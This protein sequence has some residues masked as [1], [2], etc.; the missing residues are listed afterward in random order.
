MAIWH[1]APL[2]FAPAFKAIGVCEQI[3]LRYKNLDPSCFDPIQKIWYVDLRTNS[4]FRSRSFDLLPPTPFR[5]LGVCE[6][7]WLRCKN[8]DP[9]CF[10]PSQKFGMSTWGLTLIFDP[11]PSTSSAHPTGSG[12][13]TFRQRRFGKKI[14]DVS[15]NFYC[16]NVQFYLGPLLSWFCFWF[17]PNWLGPV[18][19]IPICRIL[20]LKKNGK[21]INVGMMESIKRASD[22]SSFPLVPRGPL[23]PLIFPSC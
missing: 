6:H 23:G 13:R 15:A 22:K 21:T 14:R 3:W 8:F 17:S 4:D 11:V 20:E 7:I 2:H 5:A 16:R 10:D 9:S 12:N 1:V 19:R 18:C